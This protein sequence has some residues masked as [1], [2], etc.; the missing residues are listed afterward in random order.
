MTAPD[1]TDELLAQSGLDLLRADTGLVVHDGK[2][3]DGAR[4]PRYVLVYTTVAWPA[5]GAGNAL[6]QARSTAVATWTLH[7]VG[8]SAAAARIVAQRARVQ[9]LNQAVTLPGRGA[10]RI[11]QDQVLAPIRDEMTGGLVMDLVAIYSLISPP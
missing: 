1:A 2:V 11:K 6:T 7:C 3:P 8:E 10:G 9:L 4:P 5:E